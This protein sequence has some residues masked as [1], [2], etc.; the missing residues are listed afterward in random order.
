MDDAENWV[1]QCRRCH[2][3][4]NSGDAVQYVWEWALGSCGVPIVNGV[5]L[6]CNNHVSIAWT[7][8][9]D[10]PDEPVSWGSPYYMVSWR[11]DNGTLPTECDVARWVQW[12]RCEEP[13][14]D[15]LLVDGLRFC[16]VRACVDALRER[17]RI[18]G[19]SAI[20]G[21]WCELSDSETWR[22]ETHANWRDIKARNRA[23]SR[24]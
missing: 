19:E 6:G 7:Y 5:H 3:V 1:C 13:P 21:D 17:Q 8:W 22:A 9:H 20:V 10:E 24:W 2:G 23:R 14:L 18:P 16:S 4:H 12:T 15:W 11:P